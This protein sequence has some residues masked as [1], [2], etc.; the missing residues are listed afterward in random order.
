LRKLNHISMDKTNVTD[1]FIY[2]IIG[3]IVGF[4]FCGI[5]LQ[6]SI[7]SGSFCKIKITEIVQIIVT[8]IFG[9]IIAYQIS[10]KS[11]KSIK[12]KEICLQVFNQ[13]EDKVTSTYEASRKLIDDPN[14]I[15]VKEILKEFR[16]LSTHVFLI[17]KLAESNHKEIGQYANTIKPLYFEFKAKTTGRDFGGEQARYTDFEIL[18]IEKVYEKM[19]NEI[20]SIKI[21]LFC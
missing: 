8:I 21:K 17:E 12:R 16:R 4:L 10:V 11:G 20:V 7:V 18:E 5:V 19:V 9:T 14:S 1:H 15:Q 3:V 13:L 2:F 6:W